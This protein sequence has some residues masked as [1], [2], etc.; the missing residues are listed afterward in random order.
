MRLLYSISLSTPLSGNGNAPS[1]DAEKEKGREVPE[2]S[3]FPE[4]PTPMVDRE[5][6]RVILTEATAWL[7]DPSL[8][9]KHKL[10]AI[11]FEPPKVLKI[12][13][14]A[15]GAC[16]IIW[17]EKRCCIFPISDKLVW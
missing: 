3:K 13:Q 14:G 15:L 6:V 12:K 7:R 10:R 9:K 8:A 11:C 4:G 17:E 5:T 16:I 1:D 2:L